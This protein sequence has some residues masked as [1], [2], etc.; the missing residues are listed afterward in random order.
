MRYAIL[1]DIHANKQAWEVFLSDI[2]GQSVDSVICLGDVIGYGPMPQAVLDGVRE[3]SA[4]LVLG[5]HDAAVCGRLDSS[6]FNDHARM[7]IDWTRE[8]LEDF[9]LEFLQEVP[10]AVEAGEDVLFVHAESIE[11]GRFDYISDEFTAE[12]NL[13]ACKHRLIFCGHTHMPCV[14]AQNGDGVEKIAEG[15]IQL[16]PDKR[17][18]VNVG[19][20]GEPRL[21]DDLRGRYV[22]YDTEADTLTYRPLEFDIEAYREDLRNA[23]LDIKPFFLRASDFA[24]GIRTQ[25]LV[26]EKHAMSRLP[27]VPA[28]KVHDTPPNIVVPPRVQP[29]APPGTRVLPQDP[30]A[31]AS[32]QKQTHLPEKKPIGPTTIVVIMLAFVLCAGAAFLVLPSFLDN[33]SGG[34]AVNNLES[35]AASSAFAPSSG[36]VKV[37]LNVASEGENPPVVR[38][39]SPTPVPQEKAPPPPESKATPAKTEREGMPPVSP[40]VN[41]TDTAPKS[42]KLKDGLFAAW[43]AQRD[44]KSVRGSFKGAPKHI[45]KPKQISGKIGKSFSFNPS[46]GISYGKPE[47]HV[48]MGTGMSVSFWF[49]PQNPQDQV[50]HLLGTA[51]PAQVDA[52]GGW[53]VYAG[54]DSLG[55]IVSDG[56]KSARLECHLGHG[57]NVV[58]WRHAAVV[59][60]LEAKRL[61]LFKNGKSVGEAELTGFTAVLPA[62]HPLTF[63]VDPEGEKKYHYWGKMDDVAMWT[64]PLTAAEISK[65]HEKGAKNQSVTAI[66]DR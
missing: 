51:S 61:R 65:I 16:E 25:P 32:G 47:N 6:I 42:G 46:A 41:A 37:A 19:S 36:D 26:P 66:L 56:N 38:E 29:M 17:Y 40:K 44:F 14:F 43:P 7:V 45:G 52:L 1:S 15:E 27:V 11:P 35:D 54:R 58:P 59:V 5:N 8:R 23:G 31:M 24:N 50:K 63:G 33:D 48:L 4:A 30:H 57:G 49:H 9:D 20:A 60:D 62:P 34:L 10:L 22:I 39:E 12:A 13:A 2:A 28:T 21:A 53:S 3:K 55:V 18:L 64:R